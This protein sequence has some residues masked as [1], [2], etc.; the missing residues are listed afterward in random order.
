ML[1]TTTKMVT[2]MTEYLTLKYIFPGGHLP[3]LPRTLETMGRHGLTLL[4]AENLW[5]H[6]RRT[7]ECWLDNLERHWPEIHALDPEA[8]DERFR[9]I[10]TMYLGGTVEAFGSG[11]DLLHLTF[12]KGRDASFHVDARDLLGDEMAVPA[13][14]EIEFYK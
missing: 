8:F 3:S 10:W 2:E 11:L 4:D 13:I 7:V 12:V 14:D 1:S 9:R 6:Y 5:P